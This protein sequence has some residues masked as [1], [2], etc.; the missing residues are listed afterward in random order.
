MDD[1]NQEE[2]TNI[3]FG[4]GNN[5]HFQENAH[6]TSGR[7]PAEESLDSVVRRMRGLGLFDGVDDPYAEL[8]RERG[9]EIRK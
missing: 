8:M 2:K 9:V 3:E 5:N 7:E 6:I 4:V 1:K